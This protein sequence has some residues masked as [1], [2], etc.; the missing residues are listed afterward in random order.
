MYQ[1]QTLIERPQ[2]KRMIVSLIALDVALSFAYGL[3]PVDMT[4]AREAIDVI[5]FITMAATMLVTIRAVIRG[6]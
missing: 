1:E 2:Y 3:I 4:L 6:L 5:Q